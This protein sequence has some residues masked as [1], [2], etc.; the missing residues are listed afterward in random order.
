MKK[1]ILALVAVFTAMGL[2]AGETTVEK[3]HAHYSSEANKTDNPLI[4]E[5]AKGLEEKASKP[6]QRAKNL[7]EAVERWSNG[8]ASEA[9]KE[10]IK[11]EDEPFIKELQATTVYGFQMDIDNPSYHFLASGS[12][13]LPTVFSAVIDLYMIQHCTND[14][15]K[16]T[17]EDFKNAGAS[18]EYG[19]LIHMKYGFMGTTKDAYK[20]YI[21]AVMA[22]NCSDQKAL[23]D[24]V[25]VEIVDA[26]VLTNYD[27]QKSAS[28]IMEFSFQNKKGIECHV[29]GE[30][31]K[32]D[33]GKF[34]IRVKKQKCGI[35]AEREA[36]GSVWPFVD[37]TE[38]HLDTTFS[39]L[40]VGDKVKIFK[41]K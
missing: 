39:S 24:Y 25:G 34:F 40:N 12:A 36:E 13:V 22:F 16:I 27:T 23:L 38:N 15:S 35:N 37:N 28:Q 3:L 20:K 4:K 6:T 10:L 31:Y 7:N 32:I 18:R 29:F 33:N 9:D 21:Q 19:Q 8:T 26:T 5:V 41:T 2:Y 30:T 1:T 14:L 11:S 17:P